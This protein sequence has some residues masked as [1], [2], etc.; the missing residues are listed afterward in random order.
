[1]FGGALEPVPAVKLSPTH[2]TTRFSVL[3]GIGDGLPVVAVDG[4]LLPT[5]KVVAEEGAFDDPPVPDGALDA[6]AEPVTGVEGAFDTDAEPVTGVEGALDTD[7]VVGPL[8]A[9]ADVAFEDPW[10]G[11]AT[12]PDV[13][14]VAGDATVPALEPAPRI[15][16]GAGSSFPPSCP[17]SP[18]SPLLP[19]LPP[20][21]FPF[22]S[23][24]PKA[25]QR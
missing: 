10:A 5:A 20:P 3:A 19:R 1:V 7:A 4:A 8:G 9:F 18:A 16:A 23:L 24:A 25:M 6:D 12:T 2:A 13:G 14:L 21:C 15:G 17:A 22:P 11:E